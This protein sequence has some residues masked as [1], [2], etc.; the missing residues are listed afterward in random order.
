NQ[1]SWDAFTRGQV[2]SLTGKVSHF[3]L[4]GALATTTQLE[5]AAPTITPGSGTMEPV[6]TEVPVAMLDKTSGLAN[7]S[8][9]GSYIKVTGGPF[10]VSSIMPTEFQASCAVAGGDGG[11]S[12]QYRGWELTSGSSTIAIA[13]TFYDTFHW[14]VPNTCFS[15]PSGGTAVSNQT[16]NT[17]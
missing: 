3:L 13:T 15:P 10:T 8:L 11:M 12:T 9:K 1:T 7:D 17:L 2:V 14:Y 5:L 4:N 16:F 6:A